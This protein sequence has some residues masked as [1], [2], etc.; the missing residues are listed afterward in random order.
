[1]TSML[2]RLLQVSRYWLKTGS[3]V[4]YAPKTPQKEV[5]LHAL[6]MLLTML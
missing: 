3:E 2:R 5:I 6:N 4:T 1:M